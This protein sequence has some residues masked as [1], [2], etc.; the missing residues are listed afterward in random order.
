MSSSSKF[1]LQGRT[2]KLNSQ[3]LLPLNHRELTTVSEK[4]AHLVIVVLHFIV[5]LHKTN[6]QNNECDPAM[7]D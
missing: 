2:K 7:C 3:H 6:I 5:T 4:I 1:G